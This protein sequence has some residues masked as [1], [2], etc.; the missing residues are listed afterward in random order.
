MATTVW[1]V[2]KD[3][4]VVPSSPL[5]EGARVEIRVCET[6]PDV[7]AEL[8]AEFDAWQRASAD[9]LE[10]VERLAQESEANETR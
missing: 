10:L 7:P 1:G 5:P 3:G 8:Q 4:R 2:V 6:L 9:A